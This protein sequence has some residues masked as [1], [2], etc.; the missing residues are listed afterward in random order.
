MTPEEH[1]KIVA[2][3]NEQI[4]MME[5]DIKSSADPS[6]ETFKWSQ[7]VWQEIAMYNQ[8]GEQVDA[9]EFDWLC[10]RRGFSD[11]QR[12]TLAEALA[13]TGLYKEG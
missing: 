8:I 7:L 6:A 1:K 10:K 9:D 2:W 5:A 13:L 3:W 4:P 11:L 12:K